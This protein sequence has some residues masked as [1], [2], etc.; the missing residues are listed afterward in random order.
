MKNTWYAP[1]YFINTAGHINLVVHTGKDTATPVGIIIEAK[2][3]GNKNEMINRENLNKK[4]MQEL[5]LYYFRERVTN[6]NLE[7]KHLVVTNSIEWFIIDAQ[8]FEK[9]F[10]S[11]TKLLNLFKAFETGKLA[12]KKIDF[13]YS[14]IAAPYIEEIKQDI[15]YTYF[16]ITDYENII[17]SSDKDADNQLIGLYKVLSPQHLLKLHF[18]ND[19][20][21]LDQS[22]Y[23]ELLYI[24]GLSEERTAGKHIIVRNKPSERKE[25]SLIENTIFQLSH[26]ID[27]ENTQFEIALGLTLLWINRILF[28]KLLESQQLQY[29]K[30]NPE[31]TFLNIGRIKN[32]GDLNTLFFKVLALEPKNRPEHIRKQFVNIPYLN[33]S[34]F[35]M[36]DMEKSYFSIANLPRIDMP[37][38]P[39]T[40]LKNSN[41]NKR[42]GSIDALQYI[43]E[44]LDA[45]DFAGEGSEEIQEENKTL[46]NASVLGLIFEKINGYRDGSYFTPGFITTY[47]CRETIRQVVIDKFN[48]VKGWNVVSFDELYNTISIKDIKEANT[49]INSITICDPAVG[50]GHFLV[51]A[52]NELIAI[53]SDLGILADA[54]G[55]KLKSCI[56]EVVNDE[57]MLFDEE[58]KFY[59]YNVNNAESRRIQQTIF[60][61]KRRIIE[62][63]LFGV[64][65]NPNSV[66]ICRLRLWIELLKNTY[67]TEESGYT[68]LE[69]L[70]N[71][72]I[73]IKCGNSLISRFDLDID[74]KDELSKL[75]YTVKD[76]QE[77]VYN[78][79]NA[80][81]KAE[82]QELNK[83]IKE[84]KDTFKGG[85]QNNVS[86]FIQK[87]NLLGELDALK[88]GE[89]FGLSP[90]EQAEKEKHLHRI[91]GKIQENEEQIADIESNKIYENAFEWRFEFPELLNDAGYF[92]GFDAVIGNPPY[93]DSEAMI[94]A[95]QSNIRDHISSKYKYTKGNWDIYIA[96]FEL[97][98][99]IANKNKTVSFITPDKWL[100]KP[101]GQELR[102][103]KLDAL[104]VLARAGRNVFIEAG[105]D[106]IITI[107]GKHNDFFDFVD[108]I[109]SNTSIKSTVQKEIFEPP[110]QLDIVFSNYIQLLMNVTLKCK[111]LSSLHCICE[112]ACATSDAYT[113][114]TIIKND[115]KKSNISNYYK[116][117]NTGTI[118]KFVSRWGL[119]EI[120]YL[121]NKYL[122][123][124]VE[125]EA[126]HRTF[127]NS[128]GEK[129]NKKKI[130]IKGLT[131]LDGMLDIKGE[132]IP[133]K[134]TIIISSQDEPLLY[135]LSAILNSKFAQFYINERYSASS[136]NGGVNFTKEMVNNFPIP[137]LDMSNVDHRRV[138]NTLIALV[139]TI[140]TLK[141]ENHAAD[142]HE[143]EN[144]INRFVYEI[145][146]LTDKE[147]ESIK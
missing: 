146:G 49:I 17:R 125:K 77:A 72:D 140:I 109:N 39:G 10:I 101:F 30:K 47:I 134:T 9:Y 37:L 105:V 135:Y 54:N 23:N 111:K 103:K 65:S 139:D 42:K 113:L 35:D 32:Y 126:F 141:I 93:I 96:F 64:D 80:T 110:Y 142:T 137:N 144:K 106:A 40:V 66:K 34:L 88:Q 87:R 2:K 81:G 117:V 84:I 55:C 1:N 107:F 99:L 3:P 75:K 61:E 21:A 74:L 104:K 102:T 78:Y 53:K 90:K 63:S 73:N 119:K 12:S 68:E 131:L 138:Y 145:Y 136:Y 50:S 33:S 120:S 29:Q 36:T 41:G 112:N 114:K 26:T 18:A 8:E 13:F 19:S 116:L 62:N 70:P 59:T 56:A 25:G 86:L 51:S 82:T 5:L 11:N 57:L 130:I 98:F 38:Y 143:L 124:I 129:P 28:L 79:K 15:I 128:Y 6:N 71:I 83:L 60:Q 14:E 16:T 46:I 118:N 97:A 123:P 92:V 31:Y 121:G 108:L 132:Y 20:N 69:T 24:M 58:H 45:Y 91:E 94:H 67:Y 4:A 89:L 95:G 48:T 7:L 27:S 43:F 52:L 85:I 44:F 127:P 122:Y 100:T 147:I 115:T 133:G 22:F 76:Y